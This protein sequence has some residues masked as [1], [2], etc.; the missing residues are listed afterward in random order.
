MVDP[1]NRGQQDKLQ[2]LKFLLPIVTV[3]AK[4][5]LVSARDVMPGSTDQLTV[6]ETESTQV[7]KNSS[8]KH[9]QLIHTLPGARAGH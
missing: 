8:H 5:V 1:L 9:P 3:A 7:R 2:S 6:D 4:P